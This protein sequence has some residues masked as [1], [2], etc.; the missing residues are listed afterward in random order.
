MNIIETLKAWNQK[1]CARNAMSS[2]AAKISRQHDQKATR[3][4]RLRRY[5]LYAVKGMRLKAEDIAER[6]RDKGFNT[7]I[8]E[9]NAKRSA[10]GVYVNI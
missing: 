4:I 10:Y 6:R 7:A 8:V 1:R 3:W 5:Y 2:Y 9:L